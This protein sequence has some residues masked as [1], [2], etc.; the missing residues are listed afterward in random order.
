MEHRRVLLVAPNYPGPYARDIPAGLGYIAETLEQNG[1]QYQTVDMGLGY[2]LHHLLRR[3]EAFQPS[4]VG[5]SMMT[6]KHK[7]S[8]QMLSAIKATFPEVETMVG[9]PHV[10]TMKEEVLRD[11][12][13]I[14]FGITHEGERAILEFCQGH[15]WTQ[16]R[17][18]IYRDGGIIYTGDRAFEENLDVFPFPRYLGFELDK[19]TTAIPLISSRGCPYS[20]I[21]CHVR[22]SMGRKVRVRSVASFVDEIEYWYRQGRKRLGI[23]DDNF[24]FYRQR[25]IDICQEIRRHRLD[26]LQLLCGNGLRADKVD[27]ELLQ[28]MRDT[29]F[30]YLAFGV[31][32]GNDRVLRSLKKGE[33][34]EATQRAI[35]LACDLGYDVKL[36]FVVGAP[37]ETWQDIQDS[38]AIAARFP[39]YDFAFNNLIPYPKTEIYDWIMRNGY[40][41]IDPSV[42]FNKVPYWMNE[43]VYQ[44]PKLSIEERRRAIQEAE[45]LR[46]KVKRSY[47][48]RKLARY[49]FIS[50]ILAPV[51]ASAL[52]Q[53]RLFRQGR[54]RE[55]ARGIFYWLRGR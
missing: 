15:P 38:L 20:C 6:F 31:E 14:D 36:H 39:I 8:Y 24:T 25:V 22:N 4:L 27:R 55:F 35:A 47:F 49:G 32:G 30:S 29:G 41:V 42:Y 54:M 11:C 1:I 7:D 43:P 13:A 37:E 17:G 26:A 23:T 28:V 21:Y 18:L 16:I 51:A 12:P 46:I 5:I 50:H 44:T 45:R 52:V 9:G 48:R 33:R 53:E 2:K 34:M 19:Y 40:F 3:I 10:S